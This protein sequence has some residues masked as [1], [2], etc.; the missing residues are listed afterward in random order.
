MI[1]H[2]D[3]LAAADHPVIA[4]TA[5]ESLDKHDASFGS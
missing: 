2:I 1:R 5:P 4:E 3:D